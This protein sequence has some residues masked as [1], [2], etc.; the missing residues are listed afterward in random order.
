MAKCGHVINMQTDEE[1]SLD[2][3]EMF[4]GTNEPTKEVVNK[5]LLMFKRFQVD[6][7]E[8]KRPLKWWAKHK[9]LFPIMAFSA[10]QILGIVGS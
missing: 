2:I 10:C 3:F 9:F 4:V 6:V 8:I 1:N 5:E 7:K